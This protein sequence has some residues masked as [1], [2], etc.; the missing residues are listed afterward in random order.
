MEKRYGTL[1]GFSA[2]RCIS[3]LIED[4]AAIRPNAI[5]ISSQNQSLTY[6]ELNEKASALARHLRSQGVGRN[7]VV[8]MCIGSSPEMIVGALAILRAGGA[9]LPL[10]PSTPETRLTYILKDA[11]ISIVLTAGQNLPQGPWRTI[12]VRDKY[13]SS[14]CELEEAGFDDLAYVIYTSGSTGQPKGVEIEHR[15]LL[16]LVD[17]HQRTFSLSCN[18]RATQLAGVGFDAAVWEVWPYLTAGASLYIPDERVR[19]EPEALK[20]WFIEKGITITFVPTAI[21]ERL[22]KLE[23]PSSIPLRTVLTGADTLHQFPPQGLP[24]NIVNNYG[25]TECTVLVTS[26]IVPPGGDKSKRPTIGRPITNAT[27]HILDE[28]MREVPNET[29]GE[30]YIGGAGVA[31]GYRNRP[32]LTSS[33]FVP[34]PFAAKGGAKL[35]RTGDRAM[36]L[37]DGQIAFLGRMDDQIKIRGFRIEPNEIVTALN[38]HPSIAES[39]VISRAASAEEARLVAYVVVRADSS[40]SAT[41]LHQFI[42][43]RVPEYMQPSAFVRLE[44]LPLT[45]NGKVDKHNLPEP[46]TENALSDSDYEAPQSPVEERVAQMLEE[47]LEVDRIGMSDNFF[48]LGGHSLLGAQVVARVKETFAIE[49]SLRTIFDHPTV[50][51][52]SGEIER[53]I[54]EKMGDLTIAA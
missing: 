4:Q 36:R 14:I 24:F 33:R 18:D 30:I 25:P 38:Q 49:L 1:A 46:S 8:G 16:N 21:V 53:L 47:L 22:M 29:P 20:A 3:R 7:Q 44:Q 6:T 45:L 10:D 48:H 34:D 31:R 19:T 11:G 37:A 26:G 2:P 32:D 28:Q 5:A 51:G 13:T 27:V 9:Y 50:A 43:D 23:W 54:L 52:L 42:A 15:S 40:V 12:D 35:Y 17:W 39:A 41:E